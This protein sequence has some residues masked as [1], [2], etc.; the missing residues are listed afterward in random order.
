MLELRGIFRYDKRNFT[1]IRR[2]LKMEKLIVLGTGNAQAVHCYNTCF[3]MKK[4]EEYF[5]TDAGGGNG[6]L[7]ALEKQGIPLEKIHHIFVT[8]AHND[9]ILGMV[10][11]VRMVATSMNK[12]TYEG[13]LHIYCHRELVD[14]IK[15]LSCLTIGKKFT[16]HFD[17]R[18]L[19][20]VVESGDE[21]EILGDRFTFFD[22][23]STKA[24]QFGYRLQMDNGVQLAFPGDEPY[25]EA[26]LPFVEGAQWLLH[27]AFCLYGQR[28]R[29]KPY[30]KH[31]STVMDACRL[32]EKL[33][34][35][36]LVLWHTE[37]KDLAH[38]KDAYTAEGREYYHGNL[39]V[40]NDG[41]ILSF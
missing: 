20:H 16:A 22:I 7:L 28:E 27:E 14:T 24:K 15:T 9:H 38:R 30:E 10:W 12:G 5:L 39:Y 35:P 34:I 17:N 23:G 2:Y 40:P 36:N 8:H 41:E 3:A 6:I 32:A 37:D 29:F 19:F 21:R 4:G 11:I 33:H 26:L 31:H 18:I 13:D 25:H 1:F